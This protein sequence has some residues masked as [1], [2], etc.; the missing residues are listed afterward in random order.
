MRS[1]GSQ[2]FLLRDGCERKRSLKMAGLVQK[3]GA[4]NRQRTGKTKKPFA[5]ASPKPEAKLLVFVT[6]G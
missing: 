4:I 3:S 1:T 6:K 2:K 5:I